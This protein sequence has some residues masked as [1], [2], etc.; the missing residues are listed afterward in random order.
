MADR[1][2]ETGR[3]QRAKVPRRHHF[4]PRFYLAGFTISGKEDGELHVRDR[5][6][7]RRW[8]ATPVSFAYERDFYRVDDVPDIAPDA[9]EGLLARVEA[10]LAPVLSDIAKH[11][12][13]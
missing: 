12:R 9:V 11:R 7:G 1:T 8:K 5:Q 6:N 2:A 10:D 3:R 13:L 4:L